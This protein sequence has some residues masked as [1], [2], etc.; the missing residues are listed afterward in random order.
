MTK[1]NLQLKNSIV[2]YLNKKGVKTIQ[3]NEGMRIIILKASGAYHYCAIELNGVD[4]DFYNSK[5]PFE[6]FIINSN[7]IHEIAAKVSQYIDK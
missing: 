2:K 3:Q 1:A 4:M 7:N 5:K 6:F